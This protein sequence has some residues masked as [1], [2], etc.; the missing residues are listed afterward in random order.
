MDFRGV[1]GKAKTMAATAIAQGEMMA[2]CM[3]VAAEGWEEGE[4]SRYVQK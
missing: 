3:R 4:K 1:G 2:A